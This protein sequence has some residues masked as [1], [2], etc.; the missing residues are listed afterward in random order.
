MSGLIKRWFYAF[1][2]LAIILVLVAGFL[3]L[4]VEQFIIPPVLAKVGLADYRFSL[5]R[6]N[7]NGCSL[8]ISGRQQ[9]SSP[10][11]YG[12]VRI[13]WT[14]S[15]LFLRR[16]DRISSN[17]LHINLVD[18][19]TGKSPFTI[20]QQQ[21]DKQE[22]FTLPV[23]VEQVD[24]YNGS[25]FF[26]FRDRLAYLPL[27]FSAKRTGN[28]DLSDPSGAVYFT[29]KVNMAENEI[30]TS[31][32]LNLSEGKLHGKVDADLD[33]ATLAQ[34]NGFPATVVREINGK[35]QL[36]VDTVLQLK[37]LSVQ[38]FTSTLDSH[39]LHINGKGFSISSFGELPSKITA[40]GTLNEF[41][42]GGTG[43]QVSG[44]FASSVDFDSNFSQADS[45]IQWN[46]S[47]AI[48]PITGSF[49]G[50]RLQLQEVKPV[51][52]HHS[53]TKTDAGF[54]ARLTKELPDKS[55]EGSSFVMQYD[56]I[57]TRM[58][59]YGVEAQL[60]YEKASGP[61]PFSM[62]VFLQGLDVS[63]TTP[64]GNISFPQVGLR[65]HATGFPGQENA[66]FTG[67]FDLEGGS[68]SLEGQQLLLSGIQLTL[69]FAWP[70]ADPV[71]NGDLRSE[72]INLGGK[73]IGSFA[74]E[75][76]QAEESISVKGTFSSALI[77][78]SGVSLQGTLQVPQNNNSF[79][80][81]TFSLDG[82]HL[83]VSD[84]ASVFPTLH[85]ISGGGKVDLQGDLAFSK[86]GFSGEAELALSDGSLILQ[87]AETELENIQMHLQFPLL[88]HIRTRPR[89]QLSI[90]SI[91]KKQVLV[92]DLYTWFEIESPG[93]LFIEKISGRWSGGRVFTSSF[94]L[95]K[96]QDA[97]DVALFCDRL[98]LSSILSQFN[99]A[100]AGGEG[101]MSGRIPLLYTDGKFFVDDGFL[102]ST[103]G[104]KGHL[105][106]KQSKFL[107]TT[108]PDDVPHFSPLH[109][110]GAALADF[111]YN[112]AKLQI[113]SEEQNLVLKLQVDGKP[114]EKLPFYFDTKKNVFVRLED[115]SKGGIDQP[116]RLDV[117]FNVPLNEMYQYK[118]RF[119][120]LFKKIN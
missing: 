112:W 14:P 28:N 21:K 15:G 17:G 95:Q 105:K 90:G 2:F 52:L 69:P 116:I 58:Q 65:A 113:N 55:L 53:G 103:P 51:S 96:G 62:A 50:N 34:V 33:L 72:S 64:Q 85:G 45:S 13:D 16:I 38:K 8:H 59:D 71:A 44:P 80:D 106:I 68:I 87:D 117:N 73:K 118:D 43:F 104:E 76:A 63:A 66:H 11:F 47:L 67:H 99:L 19:Q 82:A 37:P 56:N 114:R 30:N 22:R 42:V 119:M 111:E 98:E 32:I 88:P 78:G 81:F 93:S 23:I 6:L 89:Q 91:R 5:S 48:I 57:T 97:L 70:F 79:A 10:I 39:D 74:A 102:F 120:P 1:L 35:A 3:P 26:W 27:S 109:F 86:C 12:D 31:V 25:V 36:A 40:S 107:E 24:V 61:K 100:E 101:K 60:T 4:L 94:L 54:S 18:L 29:A 20:P 49:L 9:L 110:A 83:S 108:V 7:W 41:Q 46:G 115:A 75:V 84:L 77:P 92:N